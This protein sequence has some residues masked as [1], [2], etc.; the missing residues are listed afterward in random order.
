MD[1][2]HEG[3]D[4]QDEGSDLP[5]P[6]EGVVSKRVGAD[7]LLVQLQTNEIF[8]LNP[9]AARLWEL[10]VDGHDRAE[11]ERR[12]LDEFEVDPAQLRQ[13]IDGLLGKLEEK[14]LVSPHAN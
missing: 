12:M 9:T 10:L 14:H 13:E 4:K 7:V 6:A 2:A 3:S 11:V 8:S 1:T 5:R